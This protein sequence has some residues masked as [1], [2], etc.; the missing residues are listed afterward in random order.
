MEFPRERLRRTKSAHAGVIEVQPSEGAQLV[1]DIAE[2]LGNVEYLRERG[3][4]LGSL[5][6]RGTQRGVQSHCLPRVL[7]RCALRVPA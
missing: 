5:G 7:S 1:L 6:R 3:D 4:H 2:V